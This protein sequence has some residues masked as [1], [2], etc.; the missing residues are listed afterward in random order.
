MTLPK[1]VGTDPAFKAALSLAKRVAHERSPVIIVG[2]TGSGKSHIARIIHK[3][4]AFPSAPFLEWHAGTAPES[5]LETELLG[6]QRGAAT[7]VAGRPGI[8]EATGRGTL[9][10]VGVELLQPHQQA[11]LLRILENRAF[12]RVGGG[13]PVRGNARLLALFSESPEELVARGELR[14][15][16]F[17]R[18]DVIRIE[19]PPLSRRTQD[20]P[21]L[22]EHFL[23]AACKKLKRPVPSVSAA[24]LDALCAHPWPGN[25]WEL[26]QRMEGMALSGGSLLT[27]EDLPPSFWLPGPPLETALARRFTLEELKDA[28]MRS[29]LAKVGG[30][31]TR[32]ACWLGISRKA[33]WDHLRRRGEK[34]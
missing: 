34:V 19:I 1:T 30:N 5:L 26:S 29:V 6:V 14:P 32:A 22:A 15:D 10:L 33:L 2:P 21:K 13:T 9:C 11:I 16:L 3:L 18:L 17:Y 7:G 20:V 25:L 28:Y 8:F 27:T 4:G 31:R 12:E 24:L 23:K